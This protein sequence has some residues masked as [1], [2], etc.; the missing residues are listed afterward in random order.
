M[1]KIEEEHI[2]LYTDYMPFA[3]SNKMEAPNDHVLL[4]RLPRFVVFRNVKTN[5]EKIKDM[6]EFKNALGEN[7]DVKE[8]YE[9]QYKEELKD[10][11]F[12]M[13]NPSSNLSS[14][15]FK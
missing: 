14:S 3:V 12:D 9:M 2:I 13:S 5:E 6:G 1:S 10:G 8:F 4:E 15:S 11:M 7:Y